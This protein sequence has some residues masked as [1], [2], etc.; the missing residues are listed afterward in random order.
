[1]G[2]EA[3][4][5]NNRNFLTYKGE[6]HPT[7]NAYY[8]VDFVKIHPDNSGKLPVGNF[9]SYENW[10]DTLS[11]F[12]GLVLINVD[13]LYSGNYDEMDISSGTISIAQSPGGYLISYEI[14]GENGETVIGE[15]E[16]AVIRN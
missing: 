6:V 15:Y 4:E 16:G 3:Q 2:L 5:E 7:P 8:G 10:G 11:T 12:I 13:T 1:M 14:V 9:H